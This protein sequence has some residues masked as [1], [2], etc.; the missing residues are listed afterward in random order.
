MAVLKLYGHDNAHLNKNK[1]VTIQNG[2]IGEN[3]IYECEI[4]QKNFDSN[5]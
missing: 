1:K 2:W 3:V 5:Y 4:M